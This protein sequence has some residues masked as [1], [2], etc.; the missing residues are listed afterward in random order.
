MPVLFS[1]NASAPLAASI[2]TS[3]TSITVTTGQGALF[4]AVPAGSYFYA[5]LTDSSNNLEVVKVTARSSDTL[6]VVRAQEGTVARAYAAADKIELRVTAA[7]LTNMVQLD[8]TQTV[9]GNKTFSGTVALSGGGS[10]AGTFSGT[11]T[12]SGS[13]TFSS[14]ITGSIS[15]N[16]ATVTNGVYTTGDQTIAGTK[17]FSSTIAGSINGNAATVTNGVYTVGNQTIAGDKTFTGTVI[18][19]ATRAQISGSSY[20]MLELHVPGTAARALT[21]SNDNIT[22]LSVSNGSGG[23]STTLWSVDSVGNF[24][25]SGDITAFSDERLKQNWRDLDAHFLDDL[26]LVKTG[27]Y[28][29]KD[30]GETQVG[31]GAQS[32]QGVL[33]QAVREDVTG[34]L[35]V[36]Y[37][38]AA[39]AACV[40]LAREVQALKAKVGV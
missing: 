3:S 34:M 9:T 38:N 39:L 11:A 7:G 24:T 31:V 1:N 17:T 36:A 15:G 16:A 40:M 20:A 8:G 4:P 12:F 29:R 30:T 26:A 23:T 13:I 2:T 5:T 37:G 27:I 14:T 18:M 6:T 21:I 32:L 33:P 19:S 35:S 28:E 22:R 25:A 10:I